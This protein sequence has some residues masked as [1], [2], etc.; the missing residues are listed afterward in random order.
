MSEEPKQDTEDTDTDTDTDA[1]EEEEAREDKDDGAPLDLASRRLCPDGA[2]IGVIGPDGR[3]KVCGASYDAK[4]ADADAAAD[5]V[6]DDGE[7]DDDEADG[8]EADEVEADE[9]EDK[10][11]DKD[12][13][14]VPPRRTDDGK[15]DLASRKLC[16]DGECIGVIGPDGRCKECG[17]PYTGEPRLD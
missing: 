7:V 9:V 11:K 10:D 15:L 17:K 12:K 2:C 5:E 3:C 14:K 4:A 6:D 16:S 1:A 13:D 8:V